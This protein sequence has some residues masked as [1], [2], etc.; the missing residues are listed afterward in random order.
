MEFSQIINQSEQAIPIRSRVEILKYSSTNVIPGTLSTF[1]EPRDTSEKYAQVPHASAGVFEQMFAIRHN[2]GVDLN[3]KMVVTGSL[4]NNYTFGPEI[5]NV[6]LPTDCR[7]FFTPEKG[8]LV[9]ETTGKKI[10]EL[11][12][13]RQGYEDF[14]F[15]IQATSAPVAGG[16]YLTV[17][18]RY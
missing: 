12:E 6:V 16:V 7:F 15:V 1:W 17:T 5:C 8:L 11:P 18:R 10:F 4:I 13:L 3:L 9:Q 14:T 2:L